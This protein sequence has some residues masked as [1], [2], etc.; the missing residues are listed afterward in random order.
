MSFNKLLLTSAVLLSSTLSLAHE[1][2]LCVGGIKNETRTTVMELNAKDSSHD[3]ELVGTL[4]TQQGTIVFG[5]ETN[6][7]GYRFKAQILESSGILIDEI[8]PEVPA[9]RSKVLPD[10]QEVYIN[11]KPFNM[12]DYCRIHTC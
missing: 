2:L 1:K 3:S 9:L 6:Q 11:C 12:A 8:V 4:P 7:S 5:V 10:G